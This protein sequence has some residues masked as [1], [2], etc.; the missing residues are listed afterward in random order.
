[1]AFSTCLSH[2]L[3]CDRPTS[4]LMLLRHHPY[5]A[6]LCITAVLS[7][8]VAFTAWLRRS[9]APAT[10]PFTGLMV[11]IALYATA[12]AFTTA[13][14]TTAAF[15]RWLTAE[16]ILS[17][18]VTVVFFTFTLR[19]AHR[20]NWLTPH[21]RILIWLIPLFNMG[22]AATNHWHRLVWTHFSPVEA[23]RTVLFEPHNGPGYVW[24][25][26]WFYL[27]TL[28]G[29]LLV[30]RTAQ[31]SPYIY[32]Q[33]A[34]TV[35]AST[36]PPLVAGTLHVLE[37][38][39]GVGLLPMSFLLTGCVY[40]T[41]L[42]RYRLFDL[43]PIARGTLIEQMTDSII[44]LDETGRIL[45]MNSAAQQLIQKISPACRTER[46]LLGQPITAAL[47]CCPSIL[48][49]CHAQ[50]DKE[51]LIALCKQ[52]PIHINLRLTQL[53]NKHHQSI[54]R[55]IALRD[56]SAE[57]QTRIALH[58]ANQFLAS[59][60]REIEALQDQ[61][62]EQA[63][64]DGLTGLF[65]RRYFEEMMQVEATKAQRSG[66]PL[67][68]IL[69]DIDHFKRVN[70][71]YGHQAGD[72]TLQVFADTL[73]ANIRSS[74]IACRYGGEEFIIALP[75]LTLE[76]A[77]QRAERLRLAFKRTK[78][79]FKE[80]T[81]QATISSGVGSIPEHIGDRDSLIS[82]VDKALYDAKENGRDRTQ[83][84]QT[85]AQTIQML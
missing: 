36:L 26:A 64:R 15:S 78:I 23:S 37:I 2:V 76:G 31:K 56:V 14:T 30:A 32:R 69:I 54:G 44:V 65:N 85:S 3:L 62:K 45:D 57:Y 25:A 67:A 79:Q 9:V 35:I 12:A 75:G 29:A 61:L 52:P 59:R 20:Q 77:Y 80:R 73:R 58:K 28:T 74:D 41:S 46:S 68:I 66:T 40:F 38:L 48:R 33:Q 60:L 7:G 72:L 16:S 18:L 5:F 19:F 84:I 63:I 27:Y 24:L 10:K 34:L 83:K 11:A 21:R 49:H 17:N 39:P 42:F 1:M 50:E 6:I 47:S 71:T 13:A 8:C 4:Y 55:L 53:Q 81:I 70:D 82:Q 22:L 43:L 51:V